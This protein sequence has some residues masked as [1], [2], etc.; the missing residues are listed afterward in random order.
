MYTKLSKFIQFVDD[1]IITY[2]Y[3]LFEREKKL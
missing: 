1:I 2:I 3:G